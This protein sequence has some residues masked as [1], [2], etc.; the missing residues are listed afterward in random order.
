LKGK[1]ACATPRWNGPSERGLAYPRYLENSRLAGK[2]RR[3]SGPTW[4]GCSDRVTLFG[5]RCPRW[6]ACALMPS[7]SRRHAR[8]RRQS[9]ADDYVWLAPV[10]R[11][12]NCSPP[13]QLRAERAASPASPLRGCRRESS[14][15]ARARQ[16]RLSGQVAG[17]RYGVRRDPTVSAPD[18]VVQSSIHTGKGS[19]EDPERYI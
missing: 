3:N 10:G 6:S 19:S 13:W 5:K 2:G 15:R 14:K 7:G 17:K 9:L 18:I 1:P 8:R 12:T 11:L 16:R 4:L